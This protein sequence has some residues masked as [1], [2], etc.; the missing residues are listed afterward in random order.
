MILNVVRLGQCDYGTA[1]GIQLD[2]VKKS[3][4][5]EKLE[6]HS[7]LLNTHQC[8]HLVKD[9]QKGLFLLQKMC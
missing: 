9:H 3:V 1:L 8:L 6:I 2:L 4:K 5:M 7:F